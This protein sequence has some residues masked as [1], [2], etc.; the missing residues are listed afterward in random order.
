MNKHKSTSVQELKKV[1]L[2]LQD[3]NVNI[4]ELNHQI[5]KLEKD[6]QDTQIK[7]NDLANVLHKNRCSNVLEIESLIN[8][9]FIDLNMPEAKMKIHLSKRDQL[10]ELGIT[11]V[12]FL[13]SLNKGNDYFPLEKIASGGEMSRITLAI[14]NILSSKSNL[15]TI[16]FDEIDAGIGGETATKIGDFLVGISKKR[17]VIVI[18]HFA[19]VAAKADQHLLIQKITSDEKTNSIL[20][21]LDNNKREE[22]LAK[23]ISGSSSNLLAVETAKTLINEESA[24]N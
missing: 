18:T 17:Q 16:L 19:Q 20:L 10:N 7:I 14:H 9:K 23:M 24:K 21:D 4:D 3:F 6:E 8:E 1:Y 12:S 5:N 13:V 15:P 11:D 22:E 2:E